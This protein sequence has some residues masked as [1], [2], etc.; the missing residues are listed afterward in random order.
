MASKASRAQRA[1]RAGSGNGVMGM[2]RQR[3]I[4]PSTQAHMEQ[5][6]ASVALKRSHAPGSDEIAHL[7]AEMQS[8]D[9]LVRAYERRQFVRY[10]PVGR[11][12]GCSTKCARRP[13]A[14]SMIRARWCGR[15]RGM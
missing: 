9:E 6:L 13:S 7:L 4:A 1:N 8:P 11:P 15:T 12:G 3:H 5:K 14:S 2:G 10:V